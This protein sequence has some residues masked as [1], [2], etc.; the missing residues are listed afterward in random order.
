MKVAVIGLGYWGPNLVRNFASNPQVDGIVGCDKD[1]GRLKSLQ[2]RLHG[3]QLSDN[4]AKALEDP[5]IS[6]VAIAT[7]VRTH[8]ELAKMAL[9]AGKHVWLEKPFTSTS[10]QAEKLIALASANNLRI[11][12]DHTF[13]YTSAVRKIK[14]LIVHGELGKILY[15]DSVRINLGLFQHDV[16]VVWD[17]APHD[18]SIMDYIIEEKILGLSANG[19]AQYNEQENNANISI[20]FENNRFAHCNVNWTSP[21]KIRKI[22]IG[23]DKKMLVYDDL[24]NVEKI[25][26]YDSGVNITSD[27][28]VHEALVEYRIGD[29]YSPKVQQT[30]A[31]ALGVKEFLSAISERRD[32]LTSG[33]DGLKVV[34]LLEAAETSIKN[35]G[36]YMEIR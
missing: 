27:V 28:N 7:P 19:V 32:P 20:Y 10:A 35:K 13:I 33:V 11:F 30:E 16:N 9:E 4:P 36:Q 26:I 29:M 23:G 2:S 6:A 14:E 22:I 34:K 24:E 21:V 12:V 25:K 1:A 15:F 5:D 17:L 3:V 8:F 31:L 18:L